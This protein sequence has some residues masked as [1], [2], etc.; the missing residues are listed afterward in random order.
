LRGK[1]ESISSWRFHNLTWNRQLIVA[2][3]RPA[4]MRDLSAKEVRRDSAY[5][6]GDLYRSRKPLLR[7]DLAS[8]RREQLPVPGSRPIGIRKKAI[9]RGSQ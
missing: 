6:E 5:P 7:Q 9:S 3:M 4:T 2:E 8:D 1:T